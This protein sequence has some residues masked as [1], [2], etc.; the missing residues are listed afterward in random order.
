MILGD[1]KGRTAHSR[2][3]TQGRGGCIFLE[4]DS[5]GDPSITFLVVTIAWGLSKSP[6]VGGRKI[7]KTK[8]A[9]DRRELPSQTYRGVLSLLDP[10]R[11]SVAGEVVTPS[12]D[13]QPLVQPYQARSVQGYAD[14]TC[15]MTAERV[16]RGGEGE[17]VMTLSEPSANIVRYREKFGEKCL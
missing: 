6:L 14:L 1:L 9:L 16:W 15:G 5:R 3:A 2:S 12:P 8:Y 7:L 13:Q 17:E 4:W 10:S 11:Q